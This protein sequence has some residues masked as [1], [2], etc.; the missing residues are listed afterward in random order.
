MISDRD[1][2]FL[3][4]GLAVG[5]IVMWL[6]SSHELVRLR[7]ALDLSTRQNRPRNVTPPPKPP[8]ARRAAVPPPRPANPASTVRARPIVIEVRPVLATR[9]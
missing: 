7:R 2:V 9:V 1:V 3:M 6:Y 8:D 4:I 5:V